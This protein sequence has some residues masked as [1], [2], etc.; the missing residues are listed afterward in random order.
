VKFLDKKEQVIDIELTQHGKRLLSRGK[1]KPV[2]YAFFDD[3]ILYDSEYGGFEENRNDIGERVRN[4]TPALEV[5]YVYSGIETD[6]SKTIAQKRTNLAHG[7]DEDI[8]IQ[9]TPE[10]HYAVSAPLGNSSLN[11]AEAP[12]WS[13]NVLQ[14]EISGSVL[15]ATGSQPNTKI[16]QLNMI[17]VTY[18]TTPVKPP[19]G[20]PDALDG[21]GD[22]ELD[23]NSTDVN[24]TSSRFEDGSFI[25]IQEDFLLFEVSEKNVDSLTKNFDIEIFMKEEDVATGQ[26]ILVPLLFDM[27]KPLVVNDI[28]V[29]QS[30]EP[31]ENRSL[32]PSYV[33][34]FFHVYVDD[35]IDKQTLCK[36]VPTPLLEASF[37][38]DFLDCVDV[39]VT[40]DPTGL[41]DSD[42]SE[43]DLDDE[44]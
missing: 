9:S 26:D 8:I 19:L 1:L 35:E 41:Y 29:D 30:D 32:D 23:R 12:S 27:N 31:L 6:V 33:D 15:V 18:K 42:V 17:D 44:C 11:D 25:N 43:L 40:P 21:G 10:K 5:Q 34:H 24:F 39:V 36:L 4:D 2:F 22:E 3:D 38:A 13:V 28:L 37:P 14:G 16:P 20:Q 7:I